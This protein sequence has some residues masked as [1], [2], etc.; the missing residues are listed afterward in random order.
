MDRAIKNLYVGNA[1]NIGNMEGK[2]M[3]L[4]LVGFYALGWSLRKLI[5]WTWLELLFFCLWAGLAAG[6]NYMYQILTISEFNKF[7][8]LTE[9]WPPN[10]IYVL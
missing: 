4:K 7:C 10:H 3:A 2:R 1:K 8:Y 6:L 9:L 5:K